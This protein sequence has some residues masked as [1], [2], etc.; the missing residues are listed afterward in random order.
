MAKMQVVQ[1]PNPVLH[2]K[3]QHITNFK[4]SSLKELISDMKN[5]LRKQNGL[6]L[7][8]P[9]IGISLNIFVI[10]KNYAPS[11]R[12]VWAPSSFLKPLRPTVFINAK[13]T[14]LGKDKEKIKEGC[15]SVKDT[16]HPISRSYEVKLQAQNENGVRFKVEA[17]GLLARIFQHEVDHLNGM[18]FL[19][20]LHEK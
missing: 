17:R 12:T 7:A 4:D 5:T 2:K 6:G 13:I 20:R 8:A 11:V 10:P 16:Y 15:L 9:Q 19:D 1:D 3:T 18:L 14:H